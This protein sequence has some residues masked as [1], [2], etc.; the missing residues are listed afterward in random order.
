MAGDT[1]FSGGI[2]LSVA[3]GLEDCRFAGPSG[4]SHDTMTA[5]RGQIPDLFLKGCGL[6]A[7]EILSAKIYDPALS[8]GEIADLQAEIFRLRTQGPLYIGG[9]FISYSHA[10]RE[11]VEK[12]YE[13]LRREKIT[14]WLDR[15]DLVAGPLQRQ[16]VRGIRMMDAVVLVL[17]EASVNSDWV[18]DEVRAARLKE[19][20]ESRDVLCPIALDD[21]WEKKA[22]V[23]RSLADMEEADA[24][25]A[26]LAKKNVLDFS[27]WQSDNIFEPQ[28]QKLHKGL[29]IYYT[30]TPISEYVPGPLRSHE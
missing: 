29:K 3:V 23:A 10:D 8:P 25:W 27:E 14:V 19:K 2:D 20:E 7:W 26:H 18:D 6:Q 5:S 13:R 11:A 9:V 12:L 30:P 17:S 22:G 1:T 21:K 24:H 16:I 15:H 4:I 28:F